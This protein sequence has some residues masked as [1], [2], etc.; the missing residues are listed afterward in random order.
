ME[1]ARGLF[2]HGAAVIRT[3]WQAIVLKAAGHDGAIV[4]IVI[5][6]KNGRIPGTRGAL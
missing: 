2:R 1:S 5:A 4:Q 3:S 6:S